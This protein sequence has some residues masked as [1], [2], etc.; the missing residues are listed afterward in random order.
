MKS[1]AIFVPTIVGLLVLLL[2]IY[3]SLGHAVLQRERDIAL[4]PGNDQ[5]SRLIRNEAD[6]YRTANQRQQVGILF[7]GGF[8]TAVGV[9]GW[10]NSRKRST[11]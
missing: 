1:R 10:A 5:Q 4:N 7:A 11:E 6:E 8:A 3:L 9:I 2:G